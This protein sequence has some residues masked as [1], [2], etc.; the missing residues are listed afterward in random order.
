MVVRSRM[1]CRT[2]ITDTP[3]V[4]AIKEPAELSFGFGPARKHQI[5]SRAT[6]SFYSEQKPN[7]MFWVMA[8][9]LSIIGDHSRDF[10]EHESGAN[11]SQEFFGTHTAQA[12]C[13]A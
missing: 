2:Y 5:D 13:E 3:F 9:R 8:A 1:P 11:D 10:E 4:S 7:L 6:R 12:T